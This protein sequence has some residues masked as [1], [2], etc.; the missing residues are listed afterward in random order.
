MPIKCL[1]MDSGTTIVG[2][3]QK[4]PAEL[5]EPK[6]QADYSQGI[7]P[8][9][10]SKLMGDQPSTTTREGFFGVFLVLVVLGVAAAI[11]TYL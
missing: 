8:R 2:W 9:V 5:L 1:K 10:L 4:D 3:V 11:G 6:P 7:D